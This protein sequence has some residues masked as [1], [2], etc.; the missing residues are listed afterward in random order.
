MDVLKAQYE[1]RAKD[2]EAAK[3]IV[4]LCAT[5]DRAMTVDERI[6]FD[7]TTEEFSRRS[8]MIE[9][10]KRMSAHEAE[11]RASQEGAEDQIRPVGQVVK[12]SNDVDTIRSLARGE[13]RSADFGNERRDVLTSSTGAPV[14][15]SF[16]S[17]VIMLAK[18]VGP[19]L[20]VGT[21][22]NT[23]GG[24]TI[25][26]PRLSTYSVGTVNAQAAT[27]GESDPVFSAF[28]SLSAFKY[29]FLTQISREL[30]EDSGVDIL[31]LLAMNCGT[32]LGFA[33]NTALTTGTDTTE[34]NGIVTASGSALIGGT[35]L[36]PVGSF[37]YQ[38]LVSLYY[39]LDPA[40]R[41]LPGVGF[42]ANGSSIAAMRTLKDGAGN[43]VFQPA[44]SESTPDRVLG[45]PLYENPAMAA[46]GAS[47]KSVIA[48]HFPSYY[49]RTVGGIRLDRSDDFA[50]SSDL[51][52]FRCTFRVDG[53]LPQTSHVKHFVGAAT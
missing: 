20:G 53:D 5:E 47:A 1:A 42:M 34:P 12:P 3:A 28:V 35:G 33:V 41:A 48:G 7:R 39:S 18:A 17:Q 13:I 23:A 36:T 51:I 52:T 21:T 30:L 32:S 45:V 37:T 11:V 8:T 2:L 44:M 43:F 50:F 31:S 6:T 40:A 27:L 46:I 25:Q 49:V 9:E 15:T 29:G 4:D 14:S 24:E 19:M 16:Y 26:I 38:N 10:L 22:L